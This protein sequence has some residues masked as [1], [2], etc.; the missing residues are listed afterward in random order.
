MSN[1]VSIIDNISGTILFK[2]SIEK[3]S[4]A[5][6]FATMMENEGLDIRIEAPG[7]TETLIHSLGANK[8]EISEYNKSLEEEIE[9]HENDFGC[10][11]CPPNIN[12]KKID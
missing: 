3:I 2:T 11:I 12:I 4:D 8:S 6:S 1:F 5:Y 10:M 9:D 7:L